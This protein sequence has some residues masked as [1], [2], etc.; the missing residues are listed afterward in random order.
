MKTTM[1]TR[2]R[3][4]K[5]TQALLWERGYVGTSPRAIQQRAKAGQGSMYH[6]FTG[7]SDLALT[8]IQRCAEEIKSLAAKHLSGRETALKRIET[9]L[10]HERKVLRGCQLG[11]LAQDPEIVAN[12]DLRGP[13]DETFDWIR[14]R[15]AE[16]IAEG[17]QNGEFTLSFNAHDVAATIAGV[18]QGGYVLAKAASSEE[19]YYSA[20]RG[21]LEMMT[22]HERAGDK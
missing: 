22:M 9:F 7:K 18:A 11:R 1:N 12:P 2:E 21:I 8:A 3:L 20:V 13:L 17:Q 5:S 4:I 16:V 6:H 10:L 15:L 19:P 14:K